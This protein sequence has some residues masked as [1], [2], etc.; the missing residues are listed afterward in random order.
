MPVGDDLDLWR[1]SA[2]TVVALKRLQYALVEEPCRLLR[3]ATLFEH[4]S[5][6]KRS[7]AARVD[8][9]SGVALW[10]GSN[11]VSDDPPNSSQ[12]EKILQWY[13]EKH[14]RIRLRE[15]SRVGQYLAARLVLPDASEVLRSIRGEWTL[16][17][18]NGS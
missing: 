11:I 3:C 9:S 14:H 1:A 13:M 17:G 12:V 15:A 4:L 16:D 7:P 6:V 2:G 10:P 5:H 18:V 8:V